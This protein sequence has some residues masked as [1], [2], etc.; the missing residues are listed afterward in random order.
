MLPITQGC[1]STEMVAAASYGFRAASSVCLGEG[2]I[3][4]VPPDKGGWSCNGV[5]WRCTG[6]LGIQGPMQGS[7][8]SRICYLLLSL[9]PLLWLLLYSPLICTSKLVSRDP[10]ILIGAVGICPKVREQKF[11]YSETSTTASPPL[12]SGHASLTQLCWLGGG[13]EFKEVW[14]MS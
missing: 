2:D 1:S 4:S 7:G 10:R 3:H 14:A 5:I 6:Y 8:S 9:F 11:L 13:S 12:D